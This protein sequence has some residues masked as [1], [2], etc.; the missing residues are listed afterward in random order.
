MLQIS[1]IKTK[2]QGDLLAIFL[3]IPV[4][5]LAW[6]VIAFLVA[7]VLYSFLGFETAADGSVLYITRQASFITLVLSI[8]MMI[9]LLTSMIFFR[10]FHLRL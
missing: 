7:V 4:V 3:S 8:F 9:L 6:G 2:F 1:L 10:M 5:L